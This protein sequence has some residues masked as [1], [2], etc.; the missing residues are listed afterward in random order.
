MQ[1][2]LMERRTRLQLA[3]TS[4]NTMQWRVT[5]ALCLSLVFVS[6]VIPTCHLATAKQC[7]CPKNSMHDAVVSGCS[8]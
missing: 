1:R 5:A 2:Y 4:K 8:H 3:V 7:I 6:L